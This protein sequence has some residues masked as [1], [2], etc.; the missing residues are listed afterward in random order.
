MYAKSILVFPS[1]V[2]SF[3]LPLL[4]AKLTG[5]YIIASDTPFC[6]EILNG[7]DNVEFFEEMDYKKLGEQILLR[8][9]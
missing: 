7:Y 5:T 9:Q 3:G 4:E 6:R 1:Y 2:E 8:M